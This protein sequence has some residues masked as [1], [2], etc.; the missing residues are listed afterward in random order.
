MHRG[1]CN[2]WCLKGTL[3]I[4]ILAL[5]IF[6]FLFNFSKSVFTDLKSTETRTYTVYFQ[7]K[8]VGTLTVKK[9]T[10]EKNISYSLQSNVKINFLTDYN[11]DESISEEFNNGKLNTSNHSRKV[12]KDI[13]ADNKITWVSTKYV[14]TDCGKKCK[15]ITNK[16]TATAVSIY[17]FE[18]GNDLDVYSQNYKSVVKMKKN[19]ASEFQMNLPENKKATYKYV[20]GKVHTVESSTLFGAVK[21]V[22]KP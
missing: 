5:Y 3:S 6:N 9:I 18:P 17:F 16:I 20:A 15:D 12:N 2:Q 21:F 10:E 19:K 11:I 1:I 13:K 14:V 7:S 22:L 8:D 4:M